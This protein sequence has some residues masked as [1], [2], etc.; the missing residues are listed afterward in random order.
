MLMRHPSGDIFVQ[1]ID[2]GIS[3]LTQDS[4]LAAPDHVPAGARRATRGDVVL[5]TAPYWCAEEGPLADVYA[6]ALT[7][8]V[9][10]MGRV[11]PAGAKVDL[12][13]I[14]IP[15]KLARVLKAALALGD[16]IATMD[17]FD[18]A[19]REVHDALD[20]RQAQLERRRY[21]ARV[22]PDSQVVKREA[23][24]EPTTVLPRFRD[25]VLCGELGKG[26]MGHVRVAF[27][28]EARRRV[29]LKTIQSQ[30]AGRESFKA[31]LRREY[32]ALATIDHPGVPKVF[33]YG[34][35]PEPY[36][37]M[38]I[39]TGVPLKAE[40]KIEP[41]RALSLAID[42]AEIL[43][44]AH[45]AG[46]VHRDVKP[47]NILI[48]KGDRVRLLDFGVCMLLPRYYQRELLLPATPPGERYETG[49]LEGVGTPGYTAPEIM[50]REGTSTRSDVYSVC[51][52]LSRMLTGRSLIDS[53]TA[54]TRSLSPGEFPRALGPV[55]DLLRRGTARE[56][57][58]RPRSMADLAAELEV[59][60]SGL[61]RRR[62]GL[63]EA[64]LIG[65]AVT[66]TLGLVTVLS[67]LRTLS[68]PTSNQT[69]VAESEP[70]KMTHSD[71]DAPE[72]ADRTASE[73]RISPVSV[74]H[75]VDPTM[76]ASPPEGIASEPDT[77][78]PVT[79]IAAPITRRPVSLT[80]A[81]VEA[82]L[83]RRHGEF[84][85]CRPRYRQLRVR[86]TG[87]QAELVEVD[88]MPFADVPDHV[89][90]RDALALIAFPRTA[91]PVELVVRLDLRR[92]EEQ[93]Q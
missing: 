12:S 81:A 8:T 39:V 62:A 30:H 75:D 56:P 7:L 73:P 4:D 9:L 69:A 84:Q 70:V 18:A 6:L 22:F 60:R 5:G 40:P 88:A 26:G 78:A 31:R 50:A 57:I 52:V 76:G 28:P 15:P 92:G 90:L 2:F 79:K 35:D 53:R 14:D 80:R 27:D 10:L 47:D 19:L 86:I 11:P 21:F 29:A 83:K 51:A 93:A 87:G 36:F 48:G 91:K 38:E 89:C 58:E 1:V 54:T 74:A 24:A 16:E 68:R 55:A 67:G 82:M 72:S 43:A 3:K 46:V 33:E 65:L 63:R 34:S 25:Y 20:P 23:A 17:M 32:R 71:P 44:V 66:M 64:L 61:G 85:K 13:G 77:P 42:L 37:T 41:I 59:L 49:A 45:D